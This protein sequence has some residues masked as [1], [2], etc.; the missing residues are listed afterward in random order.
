MRRARWDRRVHEAGSPDSRNPLVRFQRG[1]EAR[2]ERIRT[3]YGVLL[4][5]ALG[6]GRRFVIGFLAVV[7]LSF[8]LVPFLGQNFFPSVDAGQITLHVRAPVGSRI[9]QTSAQ[10]DRIQ[11]RI[12]QVIPADQLV[13]IVDNIG[14][15]FSSINVIYNNSGTI[16]P[17]D[18][19]ILI[20]LSKD[21][22]PT[23]GLCPQAARGIAAR[24]SR[25]D[26]FLPARRHHQ[27]DPELRRAGADRRADHRAGATRPPITPMRATSCASCR[28]FPA[29]R[30]RASSKAR[31][32]PRCAS[33]S[34]AAGSASSA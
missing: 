21:H 24:L 5:R 29:W 11:R 1:F 14:L 8:L 27:P 7:A 32:I 15:P 9:E 22:A 26:L 16:G 30:T 20:Q 33:R 34:T 18:G 28:P 3:G 25:H 19:D 2:F 23:D 4:E 31:A 10:F 13:S 6:S 12:R 17:Q